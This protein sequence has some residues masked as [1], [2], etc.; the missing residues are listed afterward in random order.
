L[1]TTNLDKIFGACEKVPR[2]FRKNWI[3]ARKIE[4]KARKIWKFLR[5]FRNWIKI[6]EKVFTSQNQ[7][8]GV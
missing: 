3:S 1:D 8:F 5:R 2:S 6:F 4:K 7:N